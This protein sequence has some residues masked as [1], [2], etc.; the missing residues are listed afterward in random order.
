M[1]N[2]SRLCCDKKSLSGQLLGHLLAVTADEIKG[3]LFFGKSAPYFHY[4]FLLDGG[5]AHVDELP[6]LG[7]VNANREQVAVRL[8]RAWLIGIGS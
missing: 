4:R 8:E 2:R 5:R 1:S 6:A 7:L 3:A